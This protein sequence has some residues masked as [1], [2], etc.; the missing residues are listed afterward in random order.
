MIPVEE[1][2]RF[3]VNDNEERVEELSVVQPIK[4]NEEQEISSER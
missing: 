1:D 4:S 2:E 3:F